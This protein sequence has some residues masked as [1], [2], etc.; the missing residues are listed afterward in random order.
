MNEKPILYC[1]PMVRATLEGRKTQTRR[2]CR[3]TDSGRMK[4]VG[5]HRNWHPEDPNAVKAA[6]YQPGT[7]LWVR[8]T[9]TIGEIVGDHSLSIVY[10]ATNDIRPDGADY[11]EFGAGKVFKVG[12][13]D[14][15]RFRKEIE[16]L[17]VEG[18]GSNWKSP[19]FLPRWAS[20]ITLEVD[21]V[22][23]QRVQDITEEDAV[24]E[25]VAAVFRHD[26]SYNGCSEEVKSARMM[27]KDLWNS[28]NAKR[29]FQWATNPWVF[30]YTFKVVGNGN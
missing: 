28:I 1:G 29:G 15:T 21:D 11:I 10:K 5:G 6:P 18:N 26:H 25:G 13:C 30:A 22:R 20:R 9:W 7:R 4:E 14:L 8:E 16:R 24:A 17:D 12:D 19:F 23:V 27:F 3:L 2:V